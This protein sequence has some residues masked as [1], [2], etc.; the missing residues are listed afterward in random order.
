MLSFSSLPLFSFLIS[1]LFLLHSLF[2]FSPFPL[3]S[4]FSLLYLFMS[5]PSFPSLSFHPRVPK[6]IA[7]RSSTINTFSSKR[8]RRKDGGPKTRSTACMRGQPLVTRTA[9]QLRRDRRAWVILV[10]LLF[11]FLI[12]VSFL[13]LSHFPIFPFLP[14]P[15]SLFSPHPLPPSSARKYLFHEL[16]PSVSLSLRALHALL[17]VRRV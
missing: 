8:R 9:R 7:S 4:R 16:C 3:S 5:S 11:F 1:H 15:L 13:P 17:F 6:W 10:C 14:L 12:V 2:S